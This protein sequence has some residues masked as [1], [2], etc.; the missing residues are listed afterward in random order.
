MKK[1]LCLKKENKKNREKLK[2]L[3]KDFPLPAVCRFTF[4]QIA[5]A[6]IIERQT[7]SRDKRKTES[8]KRQKNKKRE[9]KRKAKQT[10]DRD[11]QD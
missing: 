9:T 2:K 10:K 5:V 6:R 3:K 11:D 4:F 1:K 8:K 7:C